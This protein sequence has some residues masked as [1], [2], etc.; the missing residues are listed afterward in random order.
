MTNLEPRDP[1]GQSH[2]DPASFSPSGT[3]PL[4][5]G[6]LPLQSL[7]P[8]SYVESMLVTAVISNCGNVV[9]VLE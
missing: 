3:S 1:Y 6:T 9:V 7:D 2:C 4:H 8:A 5:I